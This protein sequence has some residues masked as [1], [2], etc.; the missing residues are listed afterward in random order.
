MADD[1][2]HQLPFRIER[3]FL[4][5]LVHGCQAC[6]GQTHLG[7][8]GQQGAFGRV[9]FQFPSG[10][11][12]RLLLA[13]ALV[14]RILLYSL[15]DFG[16]VAQSPDLQEPAQRL[17]GPQLD[18]LALMED[19]SSRIIALSGHLQDA[20]PKPDPGDGH[21]ILGQ[22]ARLVGADDGGAAKR[23]DRRQ[24]PHNGLAL[25]H[26][27]DAERQGDRYDGRKPLRNGCNRKAD[28]CQEHACRRLPVEDARHDDQN[29]ERER[30]ADQ[31]FP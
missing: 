21:F 31:Y 26:P 12:R 8:Q 3:K 14:T 7:R 28:A 15:D 24:L 30:N 19:L 27:L 20:A 13:F 4:I 10:R 18:R 6:F 16:V 22:R 5:P 17:I 1:D 11:G 9:P 2:G 23:L 29:R 25:D